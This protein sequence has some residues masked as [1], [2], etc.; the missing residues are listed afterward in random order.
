M[1]HSPA[2]A[3]QKYDICE[4][5]W[6]LHRFNRNKMNKIIRL[7]CVHTKVIVHIRTNASK[8]PNDVKMPLKYIKYSQSNERGHIS[9]RN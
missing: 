8:L 6:D 2:N 1:I 4:E 7:E 9:H 5:H 3:C